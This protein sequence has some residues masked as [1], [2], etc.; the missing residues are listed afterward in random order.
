[1]EFTIQPV[2]ENESVILLPLQPADFDELYAVACDPKIW[3]QHPKKD[4]WK[5]EVFQNFFDGAIQSKGAFKIV[6]KA[7]GNVAGSTRL[8]DYNEQDDSIMIGYTFYATKYWGT[9]FNPMVKALMLQYVF[10]F[11]SKVYFH[12]GAHNV[13]S[14][15]AIGRIG[16]KKVDE[17]EITYFGEAPMPNFVYCID[18]ENWP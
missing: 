18:R 6:E 9:G 2:L 1:M 11:V 3:E 17:R 5:K 4:R 12:I 14:Q 15:M 8:Y 16:A 10:Q 13:R 7:T